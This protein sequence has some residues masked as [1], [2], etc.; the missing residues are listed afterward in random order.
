MQ[1]H[2][3]RYRRSTITPRPYTVIWSSLDNCSPELRAEIAAFR[4]MLDSMPVCT[5]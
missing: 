5:L 1:R 2:L 4:K 3:L